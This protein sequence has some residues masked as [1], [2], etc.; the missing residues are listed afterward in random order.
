MGTEIISK[1][2]DRAGLKITAPIDYVLCL[3]EIFPFVIRHQIP[4]ELTLNV[5]LQDN[6]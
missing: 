2:T 3:R 5:H 4:P 6:I 1:D